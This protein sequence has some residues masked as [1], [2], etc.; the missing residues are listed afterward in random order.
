MTAASANVPTSDLPFLYV[1]G[2][3]AL[4]L[5]NTT[6]WTSRGPEQERLTDFDLLIKWAEGA[7]VLTSEGAGSFRAR[8]R[9][10]PQEAT[11]VFRHALETREVLQRLFQ[12][13]A[14]GETAKDALRAFNRLL[15]KALEGMRVLPVATRR[16][17]DRGMQLGWE[18]RDESLDAVLWPVVW[19]AARLVTSEDVARIRVCD[20]PDCGWIYVDRSRNR[21]RRWCQ[22]ETCGTREKTRRRY[23]RVR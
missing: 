16:R 5:V 1:G 4:D 2:D 8:A 21:L 14:S 20:G 10:R 22:M 13:L 6:D 11:A 3:P 17:R 9:A 15:G 12:S 18:S 19:S 23:R 7:G